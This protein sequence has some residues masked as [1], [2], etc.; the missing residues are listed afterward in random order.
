MTM[1]SLANLHKRPEALARC[2]ADVTLAVMNRSQT[3][4]TH[5]IARLFCMLPKARALL[6][7]HVK[8]ARLQRSVS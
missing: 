5:E 1:V 6:R 8:I 7:G 2:Y 3:T 4:V